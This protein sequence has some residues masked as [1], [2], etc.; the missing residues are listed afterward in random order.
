MASGKAESNEVIPV[1]IKGMTCFSGDQ[2]SNCMRTGR[3]FGATVKYDCLESQ[4]HLWGWGN[5]QEGWRAAWTHLIGT[6]TIHGFGCTDSL[7]LRVTG[8]V[9]SSLSSFFH[10]TAS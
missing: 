7:V 9:A 3:G 4:G 8:P 10:L 5:R 1:R 6:S 2:N